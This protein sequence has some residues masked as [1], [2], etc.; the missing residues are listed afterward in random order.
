M[1]S[2]PGEVTHSAH[3]LTVIN[4]EPFKTLLTGENAPAQGMTSTQLQ[5]ALGINHIECRDML[6]EAHEQGKLV[7]DSWNDPN[8]FSGKR[9]KL[10]VYRWKE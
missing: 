8:H 5:K 7:R 4:L 9:L 6:R 10:T 1:E 2:T 3:S